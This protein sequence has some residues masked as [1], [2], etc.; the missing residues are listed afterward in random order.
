MKVNIGKPKNWIGPYQI[1]HALCFW[2]K[3]DEYG[4]C[5]EY[6]YNFGKFLAETKDGDD[7]FLTKVCRWINSKRKQKIKVQI[8]YWDTWDVDETLAPIIHALLIKYVENLQSTAMVDK[9]DVPEELHSTYGKY[10]EQD[11][12]FSARFSFEAWKY[13]LNEMIYAFD[14]EWDN[15]YG[16]GSDDYNPEEFKKSAERKQR[17]Y[18]LFGKYLSR[19][20]N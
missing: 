10:S 8:D 17:G 4:D 2:A 1:A 7:S 14:P 16:L 20:W 13:V 5:P 9:E 6:V 11:D 3:V 12:G 15:K 18:K 19:I